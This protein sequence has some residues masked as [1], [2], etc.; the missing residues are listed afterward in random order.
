MCPLVLPSTLFNINSSV[1][2]HGY[3]N[4]HYPYLEPVFFICTLYIS[5]L[6]VFYSNRTTQAA[7]QLHSIY[8]CIE[9][10]STDILC[11]PLSRYNTFFLILLL[12]KYNIHI[13]NILW[14]TPIIFVVA[15]NLTLDVMLLE[16]YA[17]ISWIYNKNI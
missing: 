13:L 2:I 4:I 5:P 7:S 6:G 9:Y 1:L 12:I 16:F 3:W 10:Y 17:S 15:F 14:C 11:H 8:N